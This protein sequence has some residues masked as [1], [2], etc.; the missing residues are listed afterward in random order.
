[1]INIKVKLT[2]GKLSQTSQ[3]KIQIILK[4]FKYR[5]TAVSTHTP[6]NNTKYYNVSRVADQFI[7]HGME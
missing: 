6:I 5:K 7:K 3:H 4:Y 1:M 2:V